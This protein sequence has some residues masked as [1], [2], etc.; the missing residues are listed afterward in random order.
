MQ[1][2]KCEAQRAVEKKMLIFVFFVVQQFEDTVKPG[3][4]V[5]FHLRSR[6]QIAEQV[7]FSMTRTVHLIIFVL[8]IFA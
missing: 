3:Q 6:F 5:E 8:W 2:E 7:M 4:L 1:I